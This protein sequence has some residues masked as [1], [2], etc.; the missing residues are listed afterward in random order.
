[1]HA[2]NDSVKLCE[3]KLIELQKEIDESINIAGKFN[4]PV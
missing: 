3:G 2:S 4:I 1:M